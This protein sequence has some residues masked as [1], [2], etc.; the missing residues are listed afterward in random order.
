ME[1]LSLH[2]SHGIG[3]ASVLGRPATFP[4]SASSADGKHGREREANLCPS[5]LSEGVGG[6]GKRERPFGTASDGDGSAH[7]RPERWRRGVAGLVTPPPTPAASARTLMP[8]QLAARGGSPHLG[9][10]ISWKE[11]PPNR[12]PIGFNADGEPWGIALPRFS[13]RGRRRWHPRRWAV[14]D[15]NRQR[16][17]PSAVGNDRGLERA[18]IEANW[19]GAGRA[20]FEKSGPA[21]T[22]SKQLIGGN[23]DELQTTAKNGGKR[24]GEELSPSRLSSIPA[25]IG[26]EG[27]WRAGANRPPRFW[28]RGKG[29]CRPQK[30]AGYGGYGPRELPSAL[31]IDRKL[32]GAPIDANGRGGWR[33]GFKNSGP[34]TRIAKQLIGG[35]ADELQTTMENGG[36]GLGG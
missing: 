34:W 21:N 9:E 19:R 17:L 25:P 5:P 8:H 28:N 33:A 24:L 1:G 2:W 27:R 16:G 10:S 22:I 13:D 14:D 11:N 18:P 26:P 23:A 29:R 15:G 31:C 20:P 12:H 7:R 3:P 36:K 32:E 30:W 35:N 4:G 6:R